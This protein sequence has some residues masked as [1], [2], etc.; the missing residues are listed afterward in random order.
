MSYIVCRNCKNFVEVDEKV[1]L[2]FDKCEKCGHIMEFAP[3]N[4]E[5]NIVLEDIQVPELSSQKVCMSCHSMNPRETGACLHCGST[6]LHFQ[7]DFESFKNFQKVNG[8][9]NDL[10]LTNQ[11]NTIIIQASPTFSPKRNILFRLFSLM[12]GLIDFFFFSVVGLELVLGSSEFPAD[13]M[14]FVTQNLYPLMA[15][16]SVSLILA[17]LMSVM[18]I[19]KMSYRDSVE[20]SATIGVVVGLITFVVSK[21]LLTLIVSII[22]CTILTSIGG[23]IGEYIIHRLTRS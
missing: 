23:L 17:G 7:Y 1:P 4:T 5:L 15:I 6:N 19:P 3:N 18:I 12:I 13:I 11:A 10:D 9:Q 21:D 20:T 8:I 2:S 22:I 14:A 16:I